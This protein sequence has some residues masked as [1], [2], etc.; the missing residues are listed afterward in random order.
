MSKAGIGPEVSRRSFLVVMGG[1][2]VG[3]FMLPRLDRETVGDRAPARVEHEKLAQRTLITLPDRISTSDDPH[4][5]SLIWTELTAEE[6]PRVV[7]WQVEGRESAAEAMRFYNA[8]RNFNPYARKAGLVS[9]LLG[10]GQ[11]KTTRI[12]R[13][14]QEEQLLQAVRDDLAADEP[15]LANAKWLKRHGDK[16]LAEFIHLD[17]TLDPLL[18]TH[19][20]HRKYGERWWD[21]QEKGGRKWF[22]PL[23]EIGLS[24]EFMGQFMAH[25][26]LKRG[27]IEEM[28]ILR[29]EILPEHADVLFDAAPILHS[30]S[31]TYADHDIAAIVESPRMCRIRSLDLT[32]VV[33]DQDGLRSIMNS[34]NLA[35]LQ[36]LTLHELTLD[37]QG[38]RTL[39][40][41]RLM[42]QLTTLELPQSAIPRAGMQVLANSKSWAGLKSLS[43]EHCELS[44][45]G[46]RLY[47]AVWRDPEGS[48]EVGH[49]E[50]VFNNERQLK[51]WDE[52]R[53]TGLVFASSRHLKRLES[54]S[55]SYTAIDDIV[56]SAL[57][58]SGML[59][60]VGE[61]KFEH[62]RLSNTSVSRL[63]ESGIAA[64]LTSL[65]LSANLDIDSDGIQTLARCRRGQL[66][67]LHLVQ[68]KTDDD[69]LRGLARSALT[70]GLTE[71]ELTNCPLTGRGL[72][73]LAD[74]RTMRR[75]EK[76]NLMGCAVG[77]E[78][79]QVL[80]RADIFKGLKDLKY[81]L[82]DVTPEGHS[83]LQSAFPHD[84]LPA[85]DD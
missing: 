41:S 67:E 22:A 77:I 14:R 80:A 17:V 78:G 20:L 4:S 6:V 12:A 50:E 27:F 8:A 18:D 34:P 62:C 9:R 49:W 74:A 54:L 65:A 44:E 84:V 33:V 43:L 76:L 82:A 71:L 31:I 52:I 36:A 26:W 58:D 3:T 7:T 23:L 56:I 85:F 2:T 60:H 38:A 40:D 5:F 32:K 59:K 1:A 47:E 21:L 24:P 45:S 64:Q 53:E 19:P 83:L 30:L 39:S 75:L 73:S 35:T 37:E 66:R 63:V 13:S 10:R 48:D 61:L 28:E 79:A 51:R 11:A 25:L 68:T 55:L 57:V 70:A 69:A 16:R 81:L 29:P 72:K 46:P 42:P 15:R